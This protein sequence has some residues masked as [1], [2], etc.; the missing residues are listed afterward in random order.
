LNQLNL[1]TLIHYLSYDK[2][3]CGVKIDYTGSYDPVDLKNYQTGENYDSILAGAKYTTF[4][5]K[6]GTV[7]VVDWC[8]NLSKED[9]I[10]ALNSVNCPECAK[11][12]HKTESDI[13]VENI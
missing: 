5:D 12:I 7:F 4:V 8:K 1:F 6:R 10:K 13:K 9:I 2:T 11:Y 3:A